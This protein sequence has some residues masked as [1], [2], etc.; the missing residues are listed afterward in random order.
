[1]ASDR[2]LSCALRKSLFR[3][4]RPRPYR[5]EVLH[6]INHPI[7]SAKYVPFSQRSPNARIY[8]SV[9]VIAGDEILTLGES[10]DLIAVVVRI[11]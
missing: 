8:R 1:M 4:E 10:L 3:R 5:P 6:G 2:S 7:R 9:S 11:R